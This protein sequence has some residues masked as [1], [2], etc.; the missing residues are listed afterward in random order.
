MRIAVVGSGISGLSSALLLSRKHEVVL[1]EGNDYLG[2]H[3]DT[4]RVE[5]DGR[6]LGWTPASSS[7]TRSTTRC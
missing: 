1:F 5:V 6:M 2:G 7:T 3:T 4:H